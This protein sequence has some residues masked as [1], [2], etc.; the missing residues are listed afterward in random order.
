MANPTTVLAYDSS[1]LLSFASLDGRFEVHAFQRLEDASSGLGVIHPMVVVARLDPSGLE[2]CRTTIERDPV[3][4]VV[5]LAEHPSSFD[6]MDAMRA[7]ARD[8]VL[9]DEDWQVELAAR[10]DAALGWRRMVE[11]DTEAQVQS[12]MVQTELYQQQAKSLGGRVKDLEI[13]LGAE[14]A[15]V[16]Q[17]QQQLERQRELAMAAVRAK[18]VFLA[19]MTH[20]LH[21]PLNAIIGYAEMLREEL[22]EPA[23][24]DAERIMGAGRSL[25]RTLQDVLGL[26][27]LES[28]EVHPIFQ[29]VVVEDLARACL[30]RARAAAEANGVTLELRI[31]EGVRKVVSDPERL[32]DALGHLLDNA[33]K[34]GAGR[35][36]VLEVRRGP[37]DD[38]TVFVVTDQG[39]GFEPEQLERMLSPF[40]Q[41]E[42]EADRSFSGAGLGL[43]VADKITRVLNGRLSASGAKGRGAQFEILLPDVDDGTVEEGARREATVLVID[44]DPVLRR[45]LQHMLVADGHRVI[46][47]ASPMDGLSLALEHRPSLI[48]LDVL[49]PGIDGLT[50]LSRFKQ[51]PKL[52]HIPVAMISAT[53]DG[54]HAEAL[55]ACAFLHKPVTRERLREVVE[56]YAL[57]RS[58]GVSL[59]GTTPLADAM[60]AE[61]REAGVEV[62]RMGDHELPEDATSTAAFL[63]PV[64]LPFEQASSVL[65]ALLGQWDTPVIACGDDMAYAERAFLEDELAGVIVL[66]EAEPQL[67]EILRAQ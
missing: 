10:M 12:F 11:R 39:I 32:T 18:G 40:S 34:F 26:A 2:L 5:L 25:L 49:L 47:T 60:A 61:L 48:A 29:P 66:G 24:P 7:G 28:G 63:L 23:R 27:R 43:A 16:T 17:T 15:L 37:D 38:S 65:D 45:V 36:V 51:D 53:S 9:L 22:G 30:S 41:V 57:P 62:A 44:D 58:T 67:R 20:E 4:P 33:I 19:N 31:R 1:A 6:V 21:T 50:L 56:T 59:F 64:D 8:V 55:G 3:L 42:D 35:P 14:T 13:Q 54:G 46:T 52:E